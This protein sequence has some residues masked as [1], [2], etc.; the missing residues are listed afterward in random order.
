[1]TTTIHEAFSQMVRLAEAVLERTVKEVVL[2]SGDGGV[3][4]RV[5]TVGNYNPKFYTSRTKRAVNSLTV[6][7]GPKGGAA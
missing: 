7:R 1:M 2:C 6:E 5:R 4:A 3:Y